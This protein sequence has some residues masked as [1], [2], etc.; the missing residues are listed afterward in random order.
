MKNFLIVLIP[1]TLYFWSCN[2]GEKKVTEEEL[3]EFAIAEGNRIS[4]ETQQLL[5]STLKTTIQQEGIPEALR[6]CNLNAYPLVDSIEQKYSVIIKRAST[7]IRNPQDAPD[8]DE[9]Q[10]INAYQDSLVS[11]KT[12]QAFVKVGE[13]DV[14]FA[15]PILL[16]DAVCLNCH[17][18]IGADIAP[19]N[20]QVIKALYPEDKATGHELGDLRGIW[21]IRFSRE[22]L[23]RSIQAENKSQ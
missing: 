16:N 6:Y 2:P 17:G 8:E 19:E 23:A 13:K 1:A 12:P 15:R 20:Y 7:D 18:K 22:D 11:G 9:L 14:H 21:S 5:G 3:R 4:M 10:F